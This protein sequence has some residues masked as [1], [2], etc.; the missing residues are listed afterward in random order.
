MD[1]RQ[2][3]TAETSALADRLAAAMA[4]EVEAASRQAAD[5]AKA[6]A[7]A[8]ADQA[9]AEAEQARSALEKARAEAEQ[10]R[11]ALTKSRN[12]EKTLA[13]AIEKLRGDQATLQA[14]IDKYRADD[15]ARQ[16]T[17]GKLQASEKALQ[18]TIAKLQSSEKNLQGTI[19]SLRGEQSSLQAEID[20]ARAEVK[21]RQ[22]TVDKL[23]AAEKSHLST[24]DKLQASEKSLQA[25]IDKLQGSEKSTQGTISKLQA[26]EKV[27]QAKLAQAS[28]ASALAEAELKKVQ[29]ER[30]AIAEEL[31][32]AEASLAEQSR[33]ADEQARAAKDQVSKAAT[34]PL[35]QLR[36]AFQLLTAAGTVGD[37]LTVL[38]DALASEFSRVALFHVSGNRLEGRRQTGFD[39][40][41][42]I[43]KVAVPLTKGSA[44]AEAVR[45]GR[46]QGLTAAELT[47]GNRKLFGGSPSFVLILPVAV[48]K[49]IHAVIYADNSDQP[50]AQIAATKRGVHFA[51][52]LLWHAIPLI[53][54]L[55]AEEQALGELREYST[56]LLS[57]LENVYNGD[58]SAGHKGEKLQRRL[59]HNIE[60]AR[61]MFAQ[62]AQ[63]EGLDG[64][65]L[66][67]VQL[68]RLIT[69]KQGVP[70]GKD[71]AAAAR[72]SAE[73]KAEAS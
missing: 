66:F 45:S 56:Q 49:E 7:D 40:G 17:I 14:A 11:G 12:N 47:D 19:E 31:Q 24:I 65:E 27:Y 64:A 3:V 52:I 30:D 10:F 73:Q 51:E 20:T 36:A 55:A 71:L 32:R 41:S 62:R 6:A 53:G 9:R 37:V 43:S 4:A 26:S 33:A 35:D 39:F 50:K 63:D 23:Q 34:G 8:V 61:S 22:A 59:Q 54:R 38:V 42:D 46:V 15:K 28:A 18:S 58:V 60:Y 13:A 48:G 21:S 5:A 70:F 25:S 67:D 16:E 68:A 2:L 1:L 72:A 57:D 29:A 44:L 69:A